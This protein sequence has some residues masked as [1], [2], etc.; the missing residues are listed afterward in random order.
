MTRE[1]AGTSLLSKLG[2]QSQQ[3]Q[4]YIFRICFECFVAYGKYQENPMLSE[5]MFEG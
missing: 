1:H 4:A 5:N 3:H 2:F